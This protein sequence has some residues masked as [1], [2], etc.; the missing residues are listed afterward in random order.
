M[1]IE[2]KVPALSESV[3]EATL[4]AWH[5]KAGDTVNR[6]ENLIDIETDK[7]AMEKTLLAKY[8]K[9]FTDVKLF[10][11]GRNHANSIGRRCSAFCLCRF[12]MHTNARN[13][14]GSELK[15]I[16]EGKPERA[17]A[18]ANKLCRKQNF[19]AVEKNGDTVINS[20]KKKKEIPVGNPVFIFPNL[21][22]V[23]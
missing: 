8:G 15:R 23:V 17:S 18:N 1:L 7:A 22:C 10:T 9:Q 19:C 20:K 2:V 4:I 13:L 11:I 6:S 14:I 3:A 16:D 12:T 5:K 21:E